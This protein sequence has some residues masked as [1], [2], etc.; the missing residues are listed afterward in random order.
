MLHLP[1]RYEDETRVT[2]VSSLRPGFAAQVE[3]EI[4]RSEV[5]Y[6][7]R[8]QLTAVL[9][10]DTGELQLRWLNFYPS[11]QKQ[12]T[13][14]RRLRARGE[15]R[16]GLFGREMVHPRM[17]SADQP[18]P[19]S[20]TPVYPSTD[21]LPQPTLRKAIGQ[22]L[23]R[24]DLSDTLPEEARRRYGLAEFAPAVRLLHAPPP[25][26][27]EH[28]LMERIHP[29]WRRIKFDELLAQQL[30]LAA[31]RGA[32][33][34]A[35]RA[36]AGQPGRGRAGGAPV[37][38]LAVCADR[39]AAA[40]GG[41]DRRRSGAALSDA[42]PAAGRRGQRQDRGGGHRRRAGHC[43]RGPGGVD[44]AHRNPGRTAF[45]QAGGLAGAAGR[46]RGL[47][48]RQ[49]ERQ[50]APRGCRRR[51]RW[52]RAAG[53][54]HAGADPGSRHVPAAGPV[55]RRRTAPLRRGPAAGPEPQ[56][57]DRARGDRAAPAQ[58]ERHAH[59]AHAGDDLLRRSGRLGDRRIAARPH[60]GGH[61]AGGRCPTR[62]GHR[63]YRPCGAP[64]TAGV[65]GLSPGGRERGAGAADGGRYPRGDARRL[66]RPAHRAGPRTPAAGR[67]G[68]GHAR[69]SRGRDRP[70]GRHHGH[71]S[72]SRRAE[73]VADGHRACRALRAGAAAPTARPG[74][75]RHRRVDLRAAV[76]GAVVAGGAPAAARHVRDQRRI[77][78]RAA[79]S[80]AARAG[81]I[82]RHAPVRVG[83]A[84]LCRPGGRRG[85]RRAG[86]RGGGGCAPSIPRRWPP[87]WRAGCGGAR[88][89][90]VLEGPAP[91]RGGA[92]YLERV[93][94]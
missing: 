8:R 18:L 3:G 22:A 76:P 51:G 93:A 42:P 35:R 39:G 69:V 9:A 62:R 68:R 70:A 61:Q 94:L 20:L 53:G 79:R 83:L 55:H 24:A 1:L 64:G 67:E 52:Q 66:A 71:R 40:R 80:G 84:A 5:L 56:G 21:G 6:R 89:F 13:V 77:R 57:G 26:A 43:L 92:A 58:H 72:R 41:R 32:P 19:A 25:D 81:R 30:S 54:R 73:R 44:G 29:A 11:Q 14:G 48:E 15:V 7:P 17:S 85:H 27:A 88:I 12:L 37:R 2:P 74:R 63:P 10:D 50:G 60:A 38:G 65:L 87:T 45:P 4:L 23:A 46:S 49:P 90:Y 16:G 28:E 78:N 31:A 59:P 82:P 75:A 47:A 91:T 33:G 36:L 34:Q 86:A